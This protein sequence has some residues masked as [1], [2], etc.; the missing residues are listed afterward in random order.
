[1]TLSKTGLLKKHQS[2][3]NK[4]MDWTIKNMQHP[5]GYFY[6]QKKKYFSSRIPYMRWAQAWM[7]YAMSYY[8][9]LKN[10]EQK[11]E[12]PDQLAGHTGQ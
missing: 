9:L 10:R 3:A 4:V 5:S 11:H 12:R 6:Y 8:L 2:L 7:F 1:V